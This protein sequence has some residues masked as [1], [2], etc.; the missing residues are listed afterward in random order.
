MQLVWGAKPL[1]YKD[2]LYRKAYTYDHIEF[3][4]LVPY[5]RALAPIFI[6]RSKAIIILTTKLCNYHIY[7]PEIYAS[8]YVH[9]METRY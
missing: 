9:T 2:K 7:A 3:L 5:V 6:E 4:I 8:L 1:P